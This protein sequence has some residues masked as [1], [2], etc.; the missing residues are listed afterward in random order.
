MLFFDDVLNLVYLKKKSL[1]SYTFQIDSKGICTHVSVVLKSY[2]AVK[3][4]CPAASDNFSACY[5]QKGV[6]VKS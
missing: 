4:K 5:I 2:C 1:V 6:Q 3:Q